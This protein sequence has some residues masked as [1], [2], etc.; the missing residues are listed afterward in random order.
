MHKKIHYSGVEIVKC[1]IVQLKILMF[2]S[3]KILCFL[4][5]DF[6]VFSLPHKNYKYIPKNPKNN[7]N[8]KKHTPHTHQNT[9]KK[10]KQQQ[11]PK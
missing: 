9:T 2:R 3:C 10:Q 7:K 4:V 5:V 11:P 8:P 1:S 6:V